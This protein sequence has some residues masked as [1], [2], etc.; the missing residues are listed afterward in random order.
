[1]QMGILVG[2]AKGG[3][4]CLVQTNSGHITQIA[5]VCNSRHLHRDPQV[6]VVCNHLGQEVKDRLQN[7]ISTPIQYTITQ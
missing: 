3:F 1:M 6:F 4:L 7:L 2:I 5:K